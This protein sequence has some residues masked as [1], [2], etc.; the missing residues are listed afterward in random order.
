MTEQN[1]LTPRWKL[2]NNFP[3]SR[4]NVGHVFDE[5]YYEGDPIIELDFDWYENP[6]DYPFLFKQME[7]WEDRDVTGVE[8]VK[9]VGTNSDCPKQLKTI[10]KVKSMAPKMFVLDPYI[11]GL[12]SWNFLSCSEV[13]PSNLEEYN[14]QNNGE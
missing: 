7:W 9:Y 14:K 6:N 8:Y 2:I 1:L 13:L 12:G 3:G 4:Q 10:V 11:E 5:F